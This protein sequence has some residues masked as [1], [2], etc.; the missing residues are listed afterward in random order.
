MASPAD[1]FT[2]LQ[3][4]AIFL[5]AIGEDKV[6]QVLA[7]IDLETIELLNETIACLG[8]VSP[9]EKAAV[10]IEFADYLFHGKPL[11]EKSSQKGRKK[12]APHAKS[13]TPSPPPTPPNQAPPKKQ[14]AVSD[15]EETTVLKTLRKLREQLDP[16]QIDWGRAGYDFGEG[17]KGP[18][19]DRC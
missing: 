16:G 3:K 8:P 1:R 12:T 17:F 15:E 19:G 7:D 13:P 18:R 9:G 10:M 5:I 11:P 6:R 4:V 14:R 2:K